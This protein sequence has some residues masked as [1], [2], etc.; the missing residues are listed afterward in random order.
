MYRILITGGS[1]FIGSHLVDRLT[2]N[3]HFVHV[4]DNRAG[5]PHFNANEGAT[6]YNHDI[7]DD[8]VIKLIQSIQ[9]DF[10]FHLAAQIGEKSHL[11]SVS[12][13]AEVNII[14][15]INILEAAKLCHVRKLIFTSSSSI[16]GI[17]AYLGV[18]EAHPL[19]PK[20][21]Y[22]M[23]KR[24]AEE[25]IQLYARLY[26]LPYTILRLSSVYGT[27]QHMQSDGDMIAGFIHNYMHKQP[28][29]VFGDGQQTR[30]FVFIE[31]VL[32]VLELSLEKGTN[33]IF[34]IGSG[35]GTSINELINLLNA[36]FEIH[37]EPIYDTKTVV[38]M[39]EC[40]FDISQALT[41]LDW[42]PRFDLADG[43]LE[44]VHY[45]RRTLR[46]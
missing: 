12:R 26:E 18:D 21:P 40:Y 31:D 24:S 14:G 3:G 19:C 44:T 36:T 17:P 28:V 20:T 35:H 41:L 27:R 11:S 1:G 16:Y 23:S 37:V 32:D 10:I 4:I 43:I 5:D 22:G 38:N 42:S 25:Y 33:H 7:S 39:K 8:S 6:Y 46:L 29:K 9:P 15:T 2:S 13:D 30:D 34:N 45:Y